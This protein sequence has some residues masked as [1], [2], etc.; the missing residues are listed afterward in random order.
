V[1]TRALGMQDHVTVDLQSVDA[2]VGDLF[3]LCSDGLSGMIGDEEIL[4]VANSSNDLQDACR[5]LVALAN[6][7]GGE[8]NITAV[9]VRI[10]T[11]DA[12]ARDTP[13][14]EPPAAATPDGAT[15]EAPPPSSRGA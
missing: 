8:D 14:A 5:R 1:I 2:E 15:I 11:G 10:E 9:I 12:P 4:D 6:E 13:V 7:H 3:V